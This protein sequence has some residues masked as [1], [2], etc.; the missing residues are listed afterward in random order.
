MRMFKELSVA[1][2][3]LMP[4]L[5]FAHEGEHPGS[6]LAGFGHVL[7]EPDHLVTVTVL[8]AVIGGAVTLRRTVSRK[9]KAIGKQATRIQE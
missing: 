6:F 9:K 5:S 3:V 4:S 7:T 1:T 8:S 2:A